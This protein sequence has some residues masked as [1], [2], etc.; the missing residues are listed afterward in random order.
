MVRCFAHNPCLRIVVRA[1]A[2]RYA[3]VTD[4]GALGGDFCK[5][6]TFYGGSIPSRSTLAHLAQYLS[7]GGITWA[8]MGH[9]ERC[10]ARLR[11]D[12]ARSGIGVRSDWVA[13]QFECMD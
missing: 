11:L 10:R 6:H 4:R 9:L 1:S 5:P 13:A 2:S 8:F 7:F 12:R 3:M